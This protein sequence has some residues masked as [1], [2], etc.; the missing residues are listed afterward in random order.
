M[1]FDRIA[2]STD[3]LPALD[4]DA[5]IRD[6]YGQ[7]AMRFDLSPIA[8]QPLSINA[9]SLLAPGLAA[10]A[11]TL[12]AFDATRTAVM[13][14]DGNSDIMV[15]MPSE[16][17]VLVE[18]SGEPTIVNP[19]EALVAALD[20]PVRIIS[21][22]PALKTRTLQISR[23][24]LAPFV[25]DLD[26]WINHSPRFD[27][28]AANLLG[29][30]VRLWMDA[31]TGAP[32]INALAARHVI[33]LTGAAIAPGSAPDRGARGGVRAARLVA[34]KKLIRD[35][36]FSPDLSPRSIARLLGVSPRYLRLLFEAEGRS[37]RD[38]VTEQRL[39]RAFDLLRAPHLANR[40][41]IDIAYDAG[42]SDIG[43]FNRT[44]RKRFGR[45]PSDVRA[46]SDNAA[47]GFGPA[48]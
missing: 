24:A 35:R 7:I 42:F 43:T 39:K 10:T 41:I 18:G 36:L 21:E 45:T 46:G 13:R 33:E 34:A 31:G 27:T 4:R 14:G 28:S 9:D 44:F 22:A 5:S 17:L 32:A 19:G 11:A 6:Y 38:Y 37:V 15:V 20:R 23:D 2:F 16:R 1:T 29:G 25:R 47:A 8:D 30:Y 26:D 40:R 48:R 12:S 3:E